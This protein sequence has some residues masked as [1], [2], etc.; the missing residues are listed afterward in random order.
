MINTSLGTSQIEKLLLSGWRAYALISILTLILI[1]Y[2]VPQAL[3]LDPIA[4]MDLIFAHPPWASV[5]P[6]DLT[7]GSYIPS[8][9]FDYLHPSYVYIVESIRAG[10][11]PAYTS[12]SGNG[13]P[14]YF[15]MTNYAPNHL[16]IG[17]G[18]LFGPGP[19]YTCLLYTS[20]SPR[21]RQKSRMP[22]SA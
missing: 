8:D 22:S 19:G 5:R 11:L 17:L 4:P 9:Q 13:I 18:L 2:H 10:D 1:G 20:P 7:V 16:V 3:L 14:Y 21:D 6:E 15:S 12:L